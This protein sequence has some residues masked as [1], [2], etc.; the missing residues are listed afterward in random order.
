MDDD[1]NG[2]NDSM[3]DDDN[4]T[5]GSMDDDGATDATNDGEAPESA[6]TTDDAEDTAA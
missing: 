2:T 1:D 5:N 6:A 4:G 3:D